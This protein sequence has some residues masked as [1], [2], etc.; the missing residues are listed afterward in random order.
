MDKTTQD[1]EKQSSENPPTTITD[2]EKKEFEPEENDNK[3][4][5]KEEPKQ[6]EQKKKE[7]VNKHSKPDNAGEPAGKLVVSLPIPDQ[8]RCN[9]LVPSVASD[10]EERVQDVA[11]VTVAQVVRK[12]SVEFEDLKDS[13]KFTTTTTRTKPAASEP[14]GA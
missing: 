4:K 14:V 11:K 13:S 7:P 3:D 5:D 12:V 2:P 10:S 9:S 6:Q 1:E 8:S